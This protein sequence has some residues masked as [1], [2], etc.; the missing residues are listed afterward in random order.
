M[1]ASQLPLL[2]K[3]V[4]TYFQKGRNRTLEI[5]RVYIDGTIDEFPFVSIC[6]DDPR[7]LLDPANE[8]S[9]DILPSELAQATDLF[10][11]PGCYELLRL[12]EAEILRTRNFR[13][14]QPLCF[15]V[16]SLDH[17]GSPNAVL[18]LDH[19]EAM[20]LFAQQANAG[21][22]RAAPS[23]PEIA[24]LRERFGIQASDRR[25]LRAPVLSNG[26]DLPAER[27][28]TVQSA[29]LPSHGPDGHQSQ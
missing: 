27:G 7:I 17:M 6:L 14:K 22:F 2:S 21:I 10:A 24:T 19:Y 9:C 26:S 1:R 11:D 3:W 25:L 15:I 28:R 12:T 29:F 18:G 8:Q 5:R 23:E 4:C 13:P 20:S 16:V